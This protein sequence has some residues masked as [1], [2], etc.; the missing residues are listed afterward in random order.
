MLLAKR[1]RVCRLIGNSLIAVCAAVFA[2]KSYVPFVFS[3]VLFEFFKQRQKGISLAIIAISAMAITPILLLYP[4]RDC[5]VVLGL[6]TPAMPSALTTAGLFQ[7]LLWASFFVVVAAATLP[8][9]LGG[10][11]ARPSRPLRFFKMPFFSSAITGAGIVLVAA[12][13]FACFLFA[14]S[15]Q[16]IQYRVDAKLN[17][18]MITEN[19]DRLLAAA[20]SLAPQT[21]TSAQVHLVDRALYHKGALLEEFFLYPQKQDALLLFPYTRSSHRADR[22]RNMAWGAATWFELGFVNTAEHCALETLAQSYCPDM[23]GLAAK[24]YVVKNMPEAAATCLRAL[25]KDPG[26][27]SWAGR[28]LD[29]LLR[30]PLLSNSPEI[31]GVRNKAIDENFVLTGVPALSQLL[32]NRPDNKMA[33]EYLVAWELLGRNLDSLVKRVPDFRRCGYPK[34]PTL[35]EEALLLYATGKQP[36]PDPLCGYTISNKATSEF[37]RFYDIFYVKHEGEPSEAFHELQA[38]CG[39]SYYFYYLYGSSKANAPHDI[40]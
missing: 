35:F 33:L 16:A 15:K 6:L 38:V 21:L 22:F 23:L 29:S 1:S 25:R 19:W 31:C 24:I 20:N 39:S 5:G 14:N 36:I 4:I 27:A 13:F 7:T 40:F 34:L 10:I 3:C 8:C 11:G 26:Y 37:Q 28:Y 9:A 18:T 12:A 30:D 2:Q 17:A 32:R